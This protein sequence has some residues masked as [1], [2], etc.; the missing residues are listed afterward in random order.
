MAWHRVVSQ[1]REQAIPCLL[2]DVTVSTR[3]EVLFGLATSQS[4][5]RRSPPRPGCSSSA[6]DVL[7]RLEHA[8]REA[9]TA[10]DWPAL[11]RVLSEHLPGFRVPSF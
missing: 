10:L 11:C 9:R 6:E 5:D 3:A 1:L 7:V 4:A 2:H 8:S